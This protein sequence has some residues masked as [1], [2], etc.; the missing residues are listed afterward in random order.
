MKSQRGFSLLEVMLA[1]ALLAGS[2]GILIAI[3]GSGL[4]QVR[5]AA[6]AS[7]ATLHAQS[8]LDPIGVLE[9][10][11]PGRREGVSND[12]RFRWT[13]Q[14]SEAEDPAPVAPVDPDAVPLETVGLQLSNAPVLYRIELDIT[15]GEDDGVRTLRFTT[16]RAR[17]PPTPLGALP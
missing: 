5:T 7:Q 15:W 6:D 1:F 8:L 3:L 16:L 17:L 4:G 12:R 9:A 14:I 13:M 2:L 10:I 11:E